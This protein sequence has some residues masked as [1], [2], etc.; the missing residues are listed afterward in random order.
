MRAFAV[1]SL[2]AWVL[3]PALLAQRVWGAQERNRSM[4]EGAAAP[5]RKSEKPEAAARPAKADRAASRIPERKKRAWGPWA[6]GLGLALG[7]GLLLLVPRSQGPLAGLATATATAGMTFPPTPGIGSSRVRPADGMEMVYVPAGEFTMGSDRYFDEQPVHTVYL[8]ATWIDRTEVT[9][10]MYALCV[11]EGACTPPSWSSSHTRSS[12]YG[13][14]AYA[15]YPV[16]YVTWNDAD[17]YCA[18]AGGRLPSE[19]EWEKAARGTDARIYPWG[20]PFPTA[21]LANYGFH[22]G[23]TERVGSYPAGASP[24]GA[25]DMS[26]NVWEWVADRYDGT[27]YVRSPERNPQGP[28]DGSGRVLRGG[29]WGGDGGNLRAALRYGGDP[30][31]ANLN[32]GFRCS[33]REASP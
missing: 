7:I 15:D 29:S 25:L 11:A 33:G 1:R 27:Y 24:Y 3:D 10:G 2:G 17:T 21:G 4:G 9:N 20:E 8:D 31:S 19:A 5:G 12:Y 14:P 22:V 6:A 13:N 28:P 32:I 16:I 30:A 23:D 26:G 18:W